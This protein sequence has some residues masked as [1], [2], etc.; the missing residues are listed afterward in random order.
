MLPYYS[1]VSNIV[2]DKMEVVQLIPQNVNAHSYDP[3]IEDVKKLNSI[4]ILVV[5]G[6]GH[7]QFIY[8]MLNA[9]N[10][11]NEI[12]I[13]NANENTSLLEA[14]G[15]RNAKEVNSH[16]FISIKQSIQQINHIANELAKLDKENANFYKKNA[17]KYSAKLRKMLQDSLVKVKGKTKGIRVATTHAGYD[18]LLS[19]FGLS[20]YAVLEPSVVSSP[21]AT[22]IKYLIDTIKKDK[23]NI[24]FDEQGSNKKRTEYIVQETGIS[25]AELSHIT[26]GTYTKDAFD[27]FIKHNLDVIVKAIL[28]QNKKEENK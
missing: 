9:T 22:D 3:T 7:D 11:K 10:R 21:S 13:I 20:V 15:Q 23:L 14:S 28:E 27:K 25:I 2:E 16:T 8:K 26:S 19:E 6:I 5:N 12:K 24:L 1:F 17:V 4:D 18:Y